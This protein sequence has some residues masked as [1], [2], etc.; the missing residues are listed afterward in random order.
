VRASLRDVRVFEP[1]WAIITDSRL[2]PGEVHM[3]VDS[4]LADDQ[5]ISV[6]LVP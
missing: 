5:Y 6:R 1:Q 4:T 3:T 2:T